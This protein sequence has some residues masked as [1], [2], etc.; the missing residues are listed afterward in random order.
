MLP[1]NLLKKLE[2]ITNELEDSLPN[3]PFNC[4]S[5]A[6]YILHKRLG[7]DIMGGFLNME[8]HAWNCY[9]P[10]KIYIDITASQFSGFPRILILEEERAI[11]LGYNAIPGEG[12]SIIK[13]WR[14][15]EG[16]DEVLNS[17]SL[18]AAR[19]SK[20]SYFRIQ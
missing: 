4:C 17:V 19:P 7:L 13:W 14:R 18:S 16:I 9:S 10:D 20:T 15:Q 11:A 12:E 3:F 1:R 6:S 2:E 5:Y 8:S